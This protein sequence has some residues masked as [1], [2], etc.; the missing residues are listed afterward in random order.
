MNTK[1]KK[2]MVTKIVG[3]VISAVD[4]VLFLTAFAFSIIWIQ[5]NLNLDDTNN[6]FNLTLSPQMI[7]L[8]IS[9]IILSITNSVLI[10]SSNKKVKLVCGILAFFSG[11][12]GLFFWIF[13]KE[14][15][16]HTDYNNSDNSTIDNQMN[17]N[18]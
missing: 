5:K 9:Q 13:A 8:T 15:D 3:L 4:T 2:L 14:K 10:L 18:D 11:L 12:V 6:S 16:Y 1:S 7:G 17:L